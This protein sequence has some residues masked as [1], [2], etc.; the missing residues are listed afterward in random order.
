MRLKLSILI[1][2]FA[3]LL[4]RKILRKSGE[5]IAGWVLLK[6]SPR[7][8]SELSKGRTI[9]C[10]SGTNGKT[11]TTKALAKIVSSLG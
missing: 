1:A 5:T 6:L 2:K 9:I 7:A 4:S 11:S 3:A 10:V 8:I